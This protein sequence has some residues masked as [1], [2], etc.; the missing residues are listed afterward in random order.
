[1]LFKLDE[2][3]DFSSK[4]ILF[5]YMIDFSGFDIMLRKYNQPQ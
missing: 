2:E 4:K 5:S 3:V 1:M